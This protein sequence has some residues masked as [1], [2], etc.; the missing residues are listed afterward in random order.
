MPGITRSLGALPLSHAF[1]L[2]VTVVGFHVREPHSSVLMRW[3]QPEAWL[4][5]VQEHRVQ[6]A[7]AVPSML[8]LL[9]TQPVEDYD[10]SELRYVVTSAA[11]LP[12]ETAQELFRRVPSVEIRE[13]YGLTE[14]VRARLLLAARP[15]G[16]LGRPLP[17]PG[18]EVRIDDPDRQGEVGEILVRSPAVML[19]YWEYPELTAEVLRDGWLHTGDLGFLDADGYLRVVDRKKDLIIRSG[20]NVFPRDVEEA[21]LEHPS[22][23]AAGVVGRPDALHGEEVVAFVELT[24]ADVASE[25]LVAFCKG[26]SAA[27]SIPGRCTS[28]RP[29]R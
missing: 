1:G 20:F 21:L 7:A 26:G 15:R 22:V 24:S 3:F 6:I 12:P 23:A 16:R 18:I 17:V 25:D 8:K 11:P 29:Y 19:G 4:E 13:G 27:T 5:L 9:L 10:L 2:L 28:S 14:A